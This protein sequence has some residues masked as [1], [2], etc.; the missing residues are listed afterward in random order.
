LV[1]LRD[2]LTDRVIARL[3]AHADGRLLAAGSYD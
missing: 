3:E 1:E 2:L